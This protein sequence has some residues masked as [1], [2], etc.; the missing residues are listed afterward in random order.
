[1]SSA[2]VRRPAV[3]RGECHVCHLTLLHCPCVHSA[4]FPGSQPVSLDVKNIF[5]LTQLPY[6]VS[7]K[8]DGTR[9]IMLIKGTAEVYM[10]DRD[11]V[12]F[13]VDNLV[14]PKRR[15][16]EAHISLT[17]VDGVSQLRMC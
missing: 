10:V 4:G 2:A 11:N 8:A 1:M 6:R 3:G 9:Y 7:W 17:V 16:L 15:N 13:R 12:V 14:F 5:L